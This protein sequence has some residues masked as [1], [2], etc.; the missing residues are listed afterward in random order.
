MP[1]DMGEMVSWQIWGPDPWQWMELYDPA[2]Y[3]GETVTFYS[4]ENLGSLAVEI[5]RPDP[6]KTGAV[7]GDYYAAELL[8]ILGELG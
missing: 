8:A 3:I 2:D 7:V 4:T 5:E 1:V 6:P